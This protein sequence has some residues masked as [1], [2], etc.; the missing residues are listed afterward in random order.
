M[1][2]DA[3][4]EVDELGALAG[5]QRSQ[6]LVLRFSH[7]AIQLVEV[8]APLPGE[9]DVAAAVRRVGC[10]LD[11]G[12]SVSSLMAATMSLRSIA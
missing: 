6:Q 5:G 10:P 2:H 7:E 4:E 9:R 12:L 1:V 3:G 8:A 11:E